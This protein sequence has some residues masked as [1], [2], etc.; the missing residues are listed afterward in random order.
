M[1]WVNDACRRLHFFVRR[2]TAAIGKSAAGHF[3]AI[4]FVGGLLWM[5]TG[6]RAWSPPAA[7]VT[8][9]AIVMVAAALPYVL[10]LVKARRK[11]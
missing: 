7:N 5:L 10:G 4:A 6:V 2:A 8:A 11:N 1:S 9:G 3:N